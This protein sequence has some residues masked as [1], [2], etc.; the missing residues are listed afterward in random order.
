MRALSIRFLTISYR[1][2]Y[3]PSTSNRF[4]S[5]RKR[6]ASGACWTST[7]CVTSS[8]TGRRSVSRWARG[9]IRLDPLA[10]GG[11]ERLEVIEQRLDVG[12][13]KR[14]DG[15]LVARVQVVLDLPDLLV[16][17]VEQFVEPGEPLGVV[18]RADHVTGQPKL[19]QEI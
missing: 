9:A 13:E 14:D 5:K 19:R 6:I 15:Y 8:G 1:M 11:S 12:P 7:R 3:A 10:H 16:H 18:R 17:T 2:S 4:S